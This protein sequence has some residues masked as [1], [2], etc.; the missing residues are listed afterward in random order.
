MAWDRVSTP[1]H[2]GGTGLRR[3]EVMNKA[4]M[5][6]WLWRFRME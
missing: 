6:K 5:C 1:K 4:L 2:K 3:R